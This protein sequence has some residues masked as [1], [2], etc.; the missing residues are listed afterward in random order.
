MMADGFNA[1]IEEAKRHK[2]S[3]YLA[4]IQVDRLS[5]PLAKSREK[6]EQWVQENWSN[7]E[8]FPKR[9]GLMG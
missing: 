5:V 7:S 1:N 8:M 9:R 4:T 2:S 3:S 6:L